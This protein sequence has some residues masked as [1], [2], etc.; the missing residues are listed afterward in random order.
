MATQ[1]IA[2]HAPLVH[3]PN[4]FDPGKAYE[5]YSP[6]LEGAYMEGV[7]YALKHGLRSAQRLKEAGIAHA[8]MMVDLQADFRPRGRLPVSGTDDVVLRTVARL[9][10]GTFEEHYTDFVYSLDGHPPQHISYGARWRD[11]NGNPL[12]LST[13]KA[14]ILTL[15]DEAKAVFEAT[16]FDPKDGH[17]VSAG[18][19]Q[20]R[21]DPKDTVAYWH[22]LQKTGQTPWAFATHC[23]LGTDGTALHPLLAEA[24]AFVAGARSMMPTILS[25]GHIVNTDWFGPLAP[26]RIDTSHP[27]GGFQTEVVDIF[28]RAATTDVFGVAE[29]FCV[30]HFEDQVV[31]YLT[32]TDFP[33]RL[34]FVTDGTAPI[35]PN[36]PH[37]L[38]FR[39]KAAAAGV[40]FIPHDAPFEQ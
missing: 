26:C 16:C 21:F 9:L 17:P 32:G 33:A 15:A 11:Q 10:N 28:K 40:Q 7:A 3:T 19:Y 25:K 34:R 8:L 6:D 29:D 18:H 37:V 23:Q 4:F 31:T 5:W 24:L 35:V 27:Q 22:E 1:K 13:R 2:D 14:A 36:A 30:F 38:A 12:D 20:S 39:K